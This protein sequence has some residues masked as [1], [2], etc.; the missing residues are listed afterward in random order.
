MSEETNKVEETT[1]AAA[2]ATPATEAPKQ[3]V[4]VEE[5]KRRTTILTGT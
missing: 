5:P 1:P 3:E 2:E 4:K